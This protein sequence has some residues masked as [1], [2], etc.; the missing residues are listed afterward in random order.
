[1]AAELPI[2][3]FG[4]LPGQEARNERFTAMTGVGSGVAVGAA[5]AVGAVEGG[6]TV[7]RGGDRDVEAAGAGHLLRERPDQLQPGGIEVDEARLR[8]DL[9]VLITGDHP[10]TARAVSW[11]WAPIPAGTSMATATATA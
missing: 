1:M 5:D 7:G 10:A 4:S 3:C 6:A 2:I 8:A 9:P 11:P